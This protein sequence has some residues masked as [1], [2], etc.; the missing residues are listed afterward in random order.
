MANDRIWIVCKS[1][2]SKKLLAKYYPTRFAD[3]W[4]STDFDEWMYEHMHA[5]CREPVAD[6]GED[7]GFELLTEAQELS[8]RN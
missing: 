4:P 2:G 1:C 8:R 5:P 7:T 6:L 3:N